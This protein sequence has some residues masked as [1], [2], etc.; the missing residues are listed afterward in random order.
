MQKW[1]IYGSNGWIGK[2]FISLLTDV[3]VFEG[4]SRCDQLSLENEINEINPDRVISF[5]GRTSGPPELNHLGSMNT[6]IDYLEQKGKIYENVRDNL[7]SPLLIERICYERD[8]HFTYLGTGCIYYTPRNE[9]RIYYENDE[10][11]FFGSSYSVVKGF[12]DKYFRYTK[13]KVL[14]V[15]IRMP[16]S[17]TKDPKS[18]ITKIL[19][20]SKVCD[21]GKNSMSVFSDLFPVLIDEIKNEKIGTIHL[22]NPGPMLHSEILNMYQ[23]LVDPEFKYTL[24]TEEEQDNVLDAKRSTC[25]LDSSYMK[26]KGIPEL[27]DSLKRI[28]IGWKQ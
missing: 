24:M 23:E 1:L 7:F 4:K 18:L 26:E 13:G 25:V 15:R 16:V 2:Q 21:C 28:F 3:E 22:V 11:N 19:K 5:I 20:Y 9:E 17:D 12:T 8:I 14:N 10:P 6:T 27:K